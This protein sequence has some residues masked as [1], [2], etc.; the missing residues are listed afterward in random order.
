LRRLAP[1]PATVPED[2]REFLQSCEAA[3]ADRNVMLRSALV[4]IA[5]GLSAIGIEP[6]ALKGAAFLATAETAAAPA[7]WRFMQDLDLLVPEDRL[8][9][10]VK[11]L[12]RLGFVAG[13]PDYD[14]SLE[15]HYP[16]L[17]APCGTY[18]VELHTR[19]FALDD[20]SLAPADVRAQSI[21]A[22]TSP[23]IRVPA[24]HHRLMHI[25]AHTQMHNRNFARGRLVLKD[26]LDLA[27]L[28]KSDG[29]PLELSSAPALFSDPE[30]RLASAAV[31]AA[32]RRVIAERLAADPGRD[33]ADRWA[34]HA[35]ARLSWPRWR[36]RLYG[37]ADH[38][39]LELHRFRAEPGHLRR[40]ARLLTDRRRLAYAASGWCAKQR[41]YQWR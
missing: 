2:V 14:P 21:P 24:S 33:P 3:N 36:K 20:Y 34:R 1:T 10:A 23:R 7:P 32:Y 18:S 27:K 25:L 28:R 15:A 5:E 22:V 29:G 40:R 30:S 11:E 26:V 17:I 16:P 8:D 31:I 6:V 4:S 37:P 13:T 39:L 19:L 35:L 12:R 41:Q 38:I 9:D